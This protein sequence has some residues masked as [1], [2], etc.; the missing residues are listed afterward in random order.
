MKLL[1]LMVAQI[2]ALSALAQM[3]TAEEM[4]AKANATTEKAAA[5]AEKTKKDTAAA[6]QDMK[7]KTAAMKEKVM[8]NLNTASADDLAKLPGVGPTKAKAIVEGRPYSKLEDLKKVKGIKDGVISKL[9]DQ[10]TF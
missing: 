8:V 4:K 10:V 1:T 5:T 7:A 2:F 6:G 3:P 9:K